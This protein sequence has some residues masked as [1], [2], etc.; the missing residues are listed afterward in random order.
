MSDP[1]H[2]PRQRWRTILV[3]LAILAAGGYVGYRVVQSRQPYEWSG[4]VEV[5]T[6]SVGSRTAGRVKEVCVHEG[7]LLAQGQPIIVLEPGDWLAQLAQAQAQLAQSKANLEKLENGARPDELEQARGRTLEATASFD[8]TKAGARS[9]QVRAREAT[10]QAQEVAVAR[11]QIDAERLH[12]VKDLGSGAVSQADVDAADLAL[13][14]A[15]ANR[16]VSREQLLE[17]KNGSRREEIEQAQARAIEAQA[18]EKLLRAG[19]RAED[20]A[21]ARAQVAQAQGKVDEIRVMIGELTIQAPRPARVEACDLR[22][23]DL[24]AAN[25]TAATLLEEDQLYVRIY[26][27]ETEIGHIRVGQVVPIT[28]DS[29]LGRSFEGVVERINQVGEYSPR[30]LQTADERANQVF[31]TRVGIRTGRSELRAGMAA[32]IRVPK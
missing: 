20:L 26:V 12:R 8:E 24:L 15:I 13:R 21:F 4:T 18:S 6:I 3:T 7:D 19:T 2:P 31:G 29:F 11:A 28:V 32:F 14:A 10:L 16:D 25:A 9:E 30:N 22:P 5:R 23:G 1:E 27:P 17:L